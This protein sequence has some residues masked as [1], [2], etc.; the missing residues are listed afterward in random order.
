MKFTKN[1]I[2]LG[3]LIA[4][5]TQLAFGADAQQ[6]IQESKDAAAVCPKDSYQYV[7][8]DYPCSCSLMNTMHWDGECVLGARTQPTCN[9]IPLN[10]WIP[11]LLGYVIYPPAALAWYLS[12]NPEM[13]SAGAIA[14]T[15]VVAAY[16]MGRIHQPAHH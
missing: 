3:L 14:S 7:I 16:W 10:K 1:V 2:T 13:L 5:A 6:K 4:A 11:R 8:N 9:C 15:A 12:E